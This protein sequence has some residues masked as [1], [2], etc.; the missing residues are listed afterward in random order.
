MGQGATEWWPA[1]R[2]WVLPDGAVNVDFLEERFGDSIV[3]VVDTARR[4]AANARMMLAL[5]QSEA[6]SLSGVLSRCCL[7]A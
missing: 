7:V 1:A 5:L 6:P 3:T 4:A 2:D